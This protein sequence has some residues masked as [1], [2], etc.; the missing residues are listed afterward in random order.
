LGST[1]PEKKNGNVHAKNE[2]EKEELGNL[3]TTCAFG[4]QQKDPHIVM[5]RAWKLC[6]ALKGNN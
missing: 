6:L 1:S 4:Q 2:E 3:Q 5:R